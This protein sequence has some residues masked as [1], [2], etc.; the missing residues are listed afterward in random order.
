MKESYEMDESVTSSENS[1]ERHGIYLSREK[2]SSVNIS[3]LIYVLMRFN[4]YLVTKSRT[5]YR[6][7]VSSTY[8]IWACTRGFGTYRIYAQLP[9]TPHARVS[10]RDSSEPALLDNAICTKTSCARCRHKALSIYVIVQV[11]S[12]CTDTLPSTSENSK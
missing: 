1:K 7:T 2:G 11:S 4:P 5:L 9:Q 10:S 6:F 3:S 8:N 12:N